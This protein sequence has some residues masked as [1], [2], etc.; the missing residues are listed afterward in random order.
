MTQSGVFSIVDG[1]IISDEATIEMES[2]TQPG[3]LTIAPQNPDYVI[4]DDV[5]VVGSECV[6]NDC[7]NGMTFDY[8]TQIYTENN[9]EVCFDDTSTGSFP[10]N[11]WKI[12]IN[13]RTSGGASY[14]T[15]WDTTGGTRPFTIE[16]GAPANS[17]YVED[18]GRVGLGNVHT[19]C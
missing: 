16:A 1:G 10:A 18:Y 11:D 12:Q 13:D 8:C 6:G 4:N 19:L 7:A 14:F 9:M 5:I 2:A 17:L 3:S 15:I